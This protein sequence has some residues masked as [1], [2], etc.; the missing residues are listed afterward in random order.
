MKEHIL[1]RRKLLNFALC[2]V[3]TRYLTA[4]F[5]IEIDKSLAV[6]GIFALQLVYRRKPVGKILQPLTV[7]FHLIRGTFQLGSNIGKLYFRCRKPLVKCIQL[8]AVI[9][10]RRNFG[11]CR[12]DHVTRCV[13]T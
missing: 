3:K 5:I 13:F 1:L 7:K 6:K 2:T 9:G 8:S 11:L 12:K 4:G 10:I